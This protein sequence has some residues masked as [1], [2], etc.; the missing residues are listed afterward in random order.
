MAGAVE[1]ELNGSFFN[2]R[3]QLRLGRIRRDW[4][5]GTSGSSLFMN[6]IGRPCTALEGTVSPL[7]WLHFSFL[8]GALEYFREDDASPDDL[9]ANVLT[10]GQLE[11]DLLSFLHFG[12]GGAAVLLERPNAAFFSNLELRLPGLFALWGSLFVDSLDSSSDSFFYKT[13]NSY[14]Y[15]AGVKAVIRWLPLSSF[16]LRY[17]KVEPYCYSGEWIPPSPAYAGG[18]ESLGHYLP[19]NSDE[20]LLRFDAM[21]FPAVKAHLQ[22]QLLR[23]GADYG[24]GAVG[25][26][27]LN[28]SPDDAAFTKYFLMDGV[29]RWDDVVRLGAS[30]SFN[31]G[32]VPLAVFAET[33]L[34]ITRFTINGTSGSG[35]EA[36]YEALD[37]QVYPAGTGFIFSIGF[38]LYP[39]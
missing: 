25:G 31:A 9:F 20:L 18:G 16:T 17:S 38:R 12:A 22:Y 3:L 6:G 21:P 5:A 19:P 10:A 1:A 4:G 2:R 7:P 39:R 34:V 32:A 30:F 33:G 13:K 24:Y 35:N 37:D 36:E 23:H 26:S 29:Y 15:Q 14:A 8:G 27:S 11:L 28:S